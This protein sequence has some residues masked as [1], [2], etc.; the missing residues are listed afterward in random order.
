MKICLLGDG[1]VGKTALKER[2]LGKGFTTSYLL[3]IGADFA[4]KKLDLDG[5]EVKFQIWDLAGQ[6]RFNT[7]R[8][9]YYS[10][11]HGALLVFDVTR[12]DSF[13][14]VVKWIEEFRKHVKKEGVPLILIGNK[15]DIRDP[16]N[17]NHITTEMGTDL[18]TK[19]SE[20]LHGSSMT[21]PYIE[22][23]ALADVNV[24][25]AFSNLAKIIITIE[26]KK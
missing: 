6:E 14:N 13:R 22:T 2:Y 26:S 9:L 3:T 12:S 21:T 15:I 23:S 7:V 16:N 8:S 24:D 18:A 10:G 25:D 19:I 17:V 4:V 11:S 1:A 5:R 20:M